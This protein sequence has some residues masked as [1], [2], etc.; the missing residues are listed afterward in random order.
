MFPNTLQSSGTG[1]SLGFKTR[2]TLQS[3]IVNLIISSGVKPALLQAQP[4]DQ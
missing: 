1:L 3:Q 2:Y 4:G